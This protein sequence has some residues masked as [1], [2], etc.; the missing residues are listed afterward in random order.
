MRASRSTWIPTAGL[1]RITMPS[2]RP[3]VLRRLVHRRDL[4]G[5]GL[6]RI[7]LWRILRLFNTRPV[8]VVSVLCEGSTFQRVAFIGC[9]LRL[10]ALG[11]VFL[12]V[13]VVCLN[14]W[15]A[16][17]DTPA[18]LAAWCPSVSDEPTSLALHSPASSGIR[19]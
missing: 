1:T 11:N 10:V 5:V 16:G 8:D 13:S 18:K 17:F 12:Y 15:E 14:V 2:S 3:S 4:C 7:L 6:Q 9:T 19:C